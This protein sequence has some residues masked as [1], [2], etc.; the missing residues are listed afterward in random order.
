MNQKE[1]VGEYIMSITTEAITMLC[2]LRATWLVTMPKHLFVPYDKR[3]KRSDEDNEEAGERE[4]EA[5]LMESRSKSRTTQ[6]A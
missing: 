4:G 6:E 1:L 5:E 2:L 3:G